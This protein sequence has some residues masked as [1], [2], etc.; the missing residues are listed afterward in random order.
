M[1][2]G[3]IARLKRREPSALRRA[4]VAHAFVRDGTLISTRALISACALAA[5]LGCATMEP[6]IP[7][8][9]GVAFELP[10]GKTA[11]L[12][13]NGARITF[14]QVKE[15]SRCPTDVTCVWAGDA[16][17]ELTISR[18]GSSDDTK[19]LTLSPPNSEARS[20]DLQIRFVGLTPVPRQAAGNGPRAYVAQLVVNR[21]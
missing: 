19:I 5:A 21:I 6:T 7:A 4:S 16:R 9:P 12:N 8:E 18:N 13:G 17:I 20:G 3:F 11:A 14:K 15:D 10:V 1:H 2:R